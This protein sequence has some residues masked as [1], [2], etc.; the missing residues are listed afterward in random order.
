MKLDFNESSL[1]SVI[2]SSNPLSV[3]SLI[4]L[5]YYISSPE[6]ESLTCACETWRL[7]VWIPA[8][9][10][11]GIWPENSE[12]RSV[13]F[14]R[15]CCWK[16]IQNGGVS[17]DPISRSFVSETDVNVMLSLVKFSVWWLTGGLNKP[18]SGSSLHLKGRCDRSVNAS[19][20]FHPVR[21]IIAHHALLRNHRVSQCG[22]VG[23]ILF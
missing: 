13:F 16:Q 4:P 5:S 6:A 1:T 12:T 2:L 20:P 11:I 8:P 17:L 23:V 10:V 7:P 19:H 22:C 21:L 9:A 18:V 3:R 15:S 14:H